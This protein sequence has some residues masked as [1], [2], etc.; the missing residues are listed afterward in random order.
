MTVQRVPCSCDE[1]KKQLFLLQDGGTTN[2]SISS[3]VDEGHFS[4]PQRKKDAQKTSL[5]AL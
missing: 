4:L 5:K 2:P 3:I 1:A